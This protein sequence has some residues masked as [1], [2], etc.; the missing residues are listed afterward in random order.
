MGRRVLLDKA[1]L[2]SLEQSVGS[3]FKQS[4]TACLFLAA[5][6]LAGQTCPN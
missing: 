6:I 3:C 4:E 5:W 1:G 2:R